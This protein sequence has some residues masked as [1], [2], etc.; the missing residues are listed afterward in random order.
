LLVPAPEHD[1]ADNDAAAR[2][3]GN[4]KRQLKNSLQHERKGSRKGRNGCEAFLGF[5]GDVLTAPNNRSL[6]RGTATYRL[7][8]IKEK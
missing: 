2:C 3:R 8:G 7:N 5:L 4:E 6:E 1:V